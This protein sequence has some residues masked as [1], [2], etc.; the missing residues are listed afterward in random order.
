M[1]IAIARKALWAANLIAVAAVVSF[2]VKAAGEPS[3]PDPREKPSGALAPSARAAAMPLS[4]AEMTEMIESGAIVPAPKPIPPKPT[5]R[6]TETGPPEPQVFDVAANFRQEL[7]GTVIETDVAYAILQDSRKVQRLYGMGDTVDGARIV[8]IWT[9]RILIEMRG[10][11]GYIDRVKR[12]FPEPAVVAAAP[13]GDLV[14]SPPVQPGST[15]GTDEP[16]A[17]T[18]DEFEEEL[19]ELDWNV[20][21]ESQY[22]EYVQNVGRYVSQITVLSHFNAE[23]QPDGLIITRVPKDSE[24]YKRGLRKGDVI[25]SI[26]GKE[27]TDLPAVIRAAFDVLRDD[28]YLIDVV[29]VR[30]GVEEVLSYEVWPE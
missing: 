24:A 11:R 17:E 30:N 5:V 22:H 19:E 1:R 9:D 16:A 7:I 13:P 29:I 8:G 6:E 14:T 4:A 3:A 10:Q 21:T 18:F 15:I 28:E 23:K 20:M 26:Q 12:D 25:R 27:V 2:A